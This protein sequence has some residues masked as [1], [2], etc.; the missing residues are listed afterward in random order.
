MRPTRMSWRSSV[1]QPLA[2]KFLSCRHRLPSCVLRLRRS[3]APLAKSSNG[4]F[5][6]RRRFTHDVA[7]G[8]RRVSGGSTTP[9]VLSACWAFDAQGTSAACWKRYA[10]T[11]DCRSPIGLR[12]DRLKKVPPDTA[13]ASAAATLRPGELHPPDRVV[14]GAARD[15]SCRGRRKHDWTCRTARCRFPRHRRGDRRQRWQGARRWHRRRGGNGLSRSSSKHVGLRRPWRLFRI[16]L[17][18]DKKLVGYFQS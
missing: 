11:A 9:T 7:G 13:P 12:S 4:T 15:G 16:G 1:L 17:L 6:T 5:P 18:Q 14:R 2:L 10:R 3:S 8:C